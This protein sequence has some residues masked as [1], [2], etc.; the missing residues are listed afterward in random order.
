MSKTLKTDPSCMDDFDPN[1]LTVEQARKR[2]HESITAIDGFESVAIRR[3]LGRTLATAILSP[4][5]V[6]S[7]TNSAMD[8]Y[9]VN[10]RE[11]PATGQHTLSVCGTALAGHPLAFEVKAG[12]CA[13]IMTGA[14]LPPGTDTII[15][16]E[17]VER[18][19][20]V[21][22]I[23]NRSKPG[24]HVR[25]LGEDLSTGQTVLE[26]GRCITPAD[27]GLLASL[28]IAEVQ[29]RRK[30]RVAFFST[31]DELRSIGQ[32][33]ETGQIYDSNRY[34]LYGALTA[35]GV[36]IL[37][38][39]V[40]PDDREKIEQA[41]H[42]AA[43]N[44]DAMITTG[45]VSVG[46]ADFVKETLDKLGQVGF[47]K[48]SMKPGR[49]LSFGKVGKANFFGLP[50]NPVS[51]MV[52]FYQIVQPALNQMMGKNDIEPVSIQARCV[53]ALK[54][55]AGRVEYQRGIMETDEQG[56]MVVHS[57][58]HQGSHILRSMSLANCFIV[59]DLESAGA[60]AG[61]MVTIQPFYG[62]F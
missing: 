41:F 6:P 1:S 29:V 14:M 50:G 26:A 18:D 15:M 17:H 27:L 59:L 11:L 13:R 54:K 36:D 49:P 5:N 45:G 9:A 35:L 57:T 30:L 20:D 22:R 7:H 31:G 4:I 62:L 42:H 34:T 32:A 47:W 3:A 51:A 61:E 23:D 46:E 43:E 10:S 16:Q 2:I 40:I 48:I 44:A 39:G 8:G 28:G 12:Q 21:I 58:G 37:D 53:S 19:G 38:M 24:Q 52:T 55:S 25:Q 60:E 33:L 56:Q